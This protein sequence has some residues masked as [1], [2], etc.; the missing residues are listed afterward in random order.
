MGSMLQGK[1]GST[2]IERA[3]RV[4]RCHGIAGSLLSKMERK[5]SFH[6][7]QDLHKMSSLRFVKGHLGHFQAPGTDKKENI[8]KQ[9]LKME[10]R[11][12]MLSSKTHHTPP[13]CEFVMFDRFV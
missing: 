10:A 11:T 9:F 2:E 6:G 3:T 5:K 8:I 12:P 1:I 4:T 7:N 13:I